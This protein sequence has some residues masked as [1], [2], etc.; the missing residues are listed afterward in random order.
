MRRRMIEPA[1]R[2]TSLPSVAAIAPPAPAD[3]AA[4][5]AA[6]DAA[7]GPAEVRAAAG[8]H[9][10]RSGFLTDSA[11]LED[12][13][14]HRANR[15]RAAAHGDLVERQREAADT[16]DAARPLHVGDD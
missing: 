3:R 1:G 5:D 11:A 14:R 9:A 4:Q 8:A 15:I 7:D 13:R 12:L 2:L 10:R 6:L 16:I